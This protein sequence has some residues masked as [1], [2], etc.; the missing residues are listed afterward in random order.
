[1]D[2]EKDQHV[3]V[4]KP[5]N[6]ENQGN[7]KE[8]RPPQRMPSTGEEELEKIIAD[9]LKGKIIDEITVQ[10]L[11]RMV[12]QLLIKEPNVVYLQSPIF[13]VGDIHGQLND[14][15]TILGKNEHHIPMLFMG[16]Y[17][18]RG[19]Q[20]LNTFLLVIC[21]KAKYQNIT[22]LRGNH[23][24][25]FISQC[26]G[27]YTEIIANYGHPGL[28]NLCNDVFDLLPMAAVIDKKVFSVHGGL[29]PSLLFVDMIS[30]HDRFDELPQEGP[31]TDLVWSDP[32]NVNSWY[33]N[34]RGSG[35]RFG[36]NEVEKFNHLN[37]LD[38]I[39]RSH[40]LV[41]EGYKYYFGKNEDS[42]PIVTVWSAPNYA[43]RS[44]N[45]ATIMFIDKNDRRTV[46]IEHQDSDIIEPSLQDKNN[47]T[48]IYFT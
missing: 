48:S 1:M 32:E 8:R 3:R 12:S 9:I 44:N 19:Y 26:Y 38:L 42:G 15:I 28:W 31:F 22:L 4:Q 29:S 7:Q 24:S 35:Y 43:Y 30:L 6:V 27:F 5:V 23:E 33:P 46:L 16:D 18:D 25:R 47:Y 20:S 45:K 40:Q 21:Y 37:G 2:S 34:S 17:V 41:L 36:K 11:L 14:L 10:K 39:T 13:V